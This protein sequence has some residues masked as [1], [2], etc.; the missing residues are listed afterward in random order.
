MA[1]NYLVLE[2]GTV[3]E[4]EAFG[5]EKVNLAEV[6]FTTAMGGYQEYITD[7][8]NRGQILVSTYPLVGDYGIIDGADQSDNAWIAGLV[9]KEYCKDP[10][11]M[12]NGGRIDDFLKE[13][14]IPGIAGIDTRELV[15]KIRNNGTLKGAIVFDKDSIE[16]VIADLRKMP[17]YP[18]ENLV[19]EVSC[20]TAYTVDNG[21]DLTVA[22]IDCGITNGIKA[23]LSE[24]YNLKVFPYDTPA[25]T[26]MDAGVDGVFIGNG[27]GNPAHP[28]IMDT[29]VKTVKDLASQTAI[30]GICFGSQIVALALGGKTFKLKYG[31]RGG[32]QPVRCGNRIYI[33][34]QNHGYAVDEAS[35]EG[36]G[37]IVDQ[38]NINDNSV[39]GARHKDLPIITCQYTPSVPSDT[40]FVYD[41]FTK[42]MEARK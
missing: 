23:D 19:A 13:K 7:P 35:L 42:M 24:R 1:I 11:P 18:A 9:V 12:Y 27:P 25:Q 38:V 6:V 8:S 29:V 31:H 28:E 22:V 41:D 17:E 34:S 39:E 5:F 14:K 20:K 15:L 30:L 16:S 10:S 33:T 4:G 3:L 40:T 21:K 37:L 32:S 2:D 26:I 36:T